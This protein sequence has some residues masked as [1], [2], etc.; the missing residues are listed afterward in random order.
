MSSV[1][2]VNKDNFQTEVLDASTPV[3][4]DFFATWCGPCKMLAPLV[5]KV[6]Q[7][8]TGKLKVVKLDTDITP[9]IAMNYGIR[10]V[11]TLILVKNGQEVARHVGM[12]DYA[13]LTAMIGPHL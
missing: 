10:G 4:I 3:L 2:A 13:R 7:E 5:D 6:A 9:E 12:L 11:P 1:T 8:Q